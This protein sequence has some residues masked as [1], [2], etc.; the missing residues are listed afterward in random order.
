[1]AF[2]LRSA[3]EAD[4]KRQPVIDWYTNMD[5]DD[6]ALEHELAVLAHD[7]GAMDFAWILADQHRRE[8]VATLQQD[9]AA[10]HAPGLLQLLRLLPSV[11]G[12]SLRSE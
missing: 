7:L 1:V 12:H 8:A 2:L 3:I 4:D 6:P 10:L 9:A 5:L 11:R